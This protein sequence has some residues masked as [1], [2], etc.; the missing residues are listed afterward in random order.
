MF[1]QVKL[2]YAADALEPYVDTLT[3]ETHYGKHHA[4]YTKRRQA[5]PIRRLRKSWAIWMR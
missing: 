2:S 1:E 3:V 4:T 5:L